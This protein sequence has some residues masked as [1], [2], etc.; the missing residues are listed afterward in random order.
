MSIIVCGGAFGVASVRQRPPI[1]VQIWFISGMGGVAG[2]IPFD[3]NLR[4]N[5]NILRVMYVCLQAHALGLIWK[6]LSLA[7]RFKII[8]FKAIP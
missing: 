6:V 4:N 7:T 2:C 3:E 5:Y 1:P 8:Y